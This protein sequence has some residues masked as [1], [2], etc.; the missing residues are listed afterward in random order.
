MPKVKINDLDVIENRIRKDL[1]IENNPANET[2][3]D[4]INNFKSNYKNINGSSMIDFMTKNMFNQADKNIYSGDKI[5]DQRK[6]VQTMLQK[7]SWDKLYSS[8]KPRME[9]YS[10]YEIIYSYIPEL[11]SCIDSYRDSIISP[12]DLTKDTIPIKPKKS[13]LD[14][15]DEELLQENIDF[16]K[17]KY[18]L[19]NFQ[20]N[21]IRDTLKLGDQFVAILKYED[22]FKRLLLKEEN[23]KIMPPEYLFPNKRIEE[24]ESDEYQQLFEN[25]FYNDSLFTELK[26]YINEE[27]L[28]ENNYNEKNHIDKKIDVNSVYDNTVDNIK[29]IMHRVKIQFGR[30]IAKASGKN[31]IGRSKIVKEL[32]NGSFKGSIIKL[33][34]PEFTI[35]L[36]VDGMNFGY[37]FAEKEYKKSEMSPDKNTLVKDFFSSRTNLEGSLE[38]KSKE[39]IITNIFANGIAKKLDIEF[40]KDNK[41]FKELIYVLLKNRSKDKEDINFIYFSPEE[42]V[43]FAVDVN[44]VY[45]T[46][47]MAKS[48]FAAK[49]YISSLLNEQM[50]KLTRGRDK[51]VVY[52][53]IGLDEAAEEAIQEVIRDIK[54]KE[55]QTDNL[56]SLT[57]M[58]RTVGNFEDYYIP[59]FDG[60]KNIEFDTIQ[61]INEIGPH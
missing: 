14:E 37:L 10:E 38:K 60:E 23:D 28:L 29:N 11:A 53:E 59:V 44:K 46:S 16:L 27:V 12:D 36:E 5:I 21:V 26:E 48:L 41:E 1:E 47:R 8:E 24:I 32:E 2:L 55:I 57:T 51:R 15:E 50:Q 33:L 22:E 17:E 34:E 39:E 4:K 19:E 45:G 3:E 13:V 20:K 58:L 40:I 49:L 18:N 54:S 31:K 35:K 6:Y 42:V 9:K 25:T 30:D 56:R 43:H 61:G 52:T 7:S